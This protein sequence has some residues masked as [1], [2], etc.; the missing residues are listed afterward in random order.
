M[1]EF[2][3]KIK[4]M[5]LMAVAAEA[6]QEVAELR[7]QLALTPEQETAFRE[8]S[9]R[10]I[11]QAADQINVTLSWL[12]NSMVTGNP[13]EAAPV[14]RLSNRELWEP[15]LT[16]QQLAAYDAFVVARQRRERA[17]QLAN[18]RINRIAE[19]QLT[20]DQRNRVCE[21]FMMSEE[22][23]LAATGGYLEPST[24]TYLEN[25]SLASVLTPKQ[26]K[27]YLELTASPG[28]TKRKWYAWGAFIPP[29]FNLPSSPGG[30][31]GGGS[32]RAH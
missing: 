19:L 31:F 18:E 21:I 11:K 1:R 23:G 12:S 26:Y 17:A 8:A 27:K 4:L 5:I 7:P 16:P 28:S 13:G 9:G 10:Q 25:K 20:E 32:F 22:K 15:I 14:R 3:E 24:D 30:A 6:E 29:V 2:Q